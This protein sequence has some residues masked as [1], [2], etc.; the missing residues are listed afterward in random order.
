[1]IKFL[2]IV[3][4]IFLLHTRAYIYENLLSPNCFHVNRKSISAILCNHKGNK[5]Y[6]EKKFYSIYRIRGFGIQSLNRCM[7]RSLLNANTKSSNI[8]NNLKK[9]KIRTENQSSIT[10]K[11]YDTFV[12]VGEL[13]YSLSNAF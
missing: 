3:S 13:K 9:K 1:M 8:F 5:Q 12:Q 11:M 4:F 2:S 7:F 6:T 10:I